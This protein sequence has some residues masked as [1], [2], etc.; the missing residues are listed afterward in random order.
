VSTTHL[1]ETA[2]ATITNWLVHV[3]GAPAYVVVGALVFSE[4][5]LFVGFFIPGETAVVVGGVLASVGSV[6]LWLMMT[7]V[8]ACA[9][10]GDNVGFIAGETAGPRLLARSGVRGKAAIARTAAQVD[11]HGGPA[12]LLARFVPFGRAV[13]PGIAGISR[14]RYRTFLTFNLIGG[15][16]WGVSFALLG[17]IIGRPF[18]RVLSD[19]RTAALLV[20]GSIVV[21]IL[22]RTLIRLYRRSHPTESG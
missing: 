13:V 14:M 10:A 12:V 20:L 17:Y 7:V 1:M 8:V 5:A 19:L 3:H 16:L 9:I 15:I 21:S 6:R 4:T 18:L 22:G 2:F 11:R